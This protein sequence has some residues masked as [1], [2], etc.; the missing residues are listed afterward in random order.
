[1]CDTI[2]TSMFNT[3][4]YKNLKV[5]SIHQCYMSAIAIQRKDLLPPT[6]YS[7]EILRCLYLPHSISLS[8]MGVRAEHIKLVLHMVS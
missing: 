2:N 7:S 5:C 4:I 3:E 6:L 8:R 1:M